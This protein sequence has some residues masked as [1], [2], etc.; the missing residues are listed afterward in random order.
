MYLFQEL[1]SQRDSSGISYLQNDNRLWQV[2]KVR[3]K[4]GLALGGGAAKGLAH[5]GVLEALVAADIP[6]DMIAGTSMGAIVGAFYAISGDLPL[7]HRMAV[8]LGKKRLGLFTDLKIPRTGIL[9]WSKVEKQLNNYIGN[10]T[11]E[12]LRLPFQC[13]AVDIDSGEELV[14]K[15][16][17]VWNAIRASASVPVMLP[18]TEIGGQHL[19]DGGILNP[20]PVRLARDMGAEM[21]IAVNVLPKLDKPEPKPHHHTIFTIMLKTMYIF[22]DKV[23]V[24]SLE[25]ADIVILPDTLSVGYTDFHKAE[26]CILEGRL[27]AEKMVPE[28]RRMLDLTPDEAVANAD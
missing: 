9:S 12:D 4:V 3:K 22:N 16:G 18:I 1:N 6:I 27:A 21:V 24:S 14:L 25:G 15:E 26:E 13:V 10:V 19:V 17:K 11:F 2:K 8:E 7:M 5:I 28:I 20:V 23:I